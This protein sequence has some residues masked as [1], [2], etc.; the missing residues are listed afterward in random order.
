MHLVLEGRAM[1][2]NKGGLGQQIKLVGVTDFP[3]RSRVTFGQ[4]LDL[5]ESQ[6]SHLLKWYNKPH[7]EVCWKD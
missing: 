4:F 1:Q 5:S 2:G 3:L 6:V 7:L